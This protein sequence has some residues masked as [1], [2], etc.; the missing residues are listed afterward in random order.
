MHLCC[1]HYAMTAL[2][3]CNLVL[4]APWMNNLLFS[5]GYYTMPY[6][7]MIVSQKMRFF[8]MTHRL[9]NQCNFLGHQVHDI[10]YRNQFETYEKYQI[11]FP[12]DVL[13]SQT[14]S[15]FQD[16]T[17]NLEIVDR[18]TMKPKVKLVSWLQKW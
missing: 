5:T 18:F 3:Q 7:G 4:I 14:K 11:I 9:D 6:F 1:N 13:N 12:S 2:Q 15:T 8:V 17:F 16:L 10:T